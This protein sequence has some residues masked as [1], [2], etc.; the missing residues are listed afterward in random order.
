MVHKNNNRIR[1]SL[2]DETVLDDIDLISRIM[3]LC[4]CQDSLES[5]DSSGSHSPSSS[6]GKHR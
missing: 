5:L 2:L 4:D 6:T 3:Y 1:L